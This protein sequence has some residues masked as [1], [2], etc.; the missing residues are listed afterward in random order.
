MDKHFHTDFEDWVRDPL[1][2]QEIRLYLS[3]TLDTLDNHTQLGNVLVF[4]TEYW[5]I[6]DIAE[7]LLTTIPYHPQFMSI[8]DRIIQQRPFYDKVDLLSFICVDEPQDQVI[9]IVRA[10]RH[11]ISDALLNHVGYKLAWDTKLLKELINIK[12]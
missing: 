8:V 3:R 9:L 4:I 10:L 11:S 5:T 1:N 7:L 2:M 6:V 12:L